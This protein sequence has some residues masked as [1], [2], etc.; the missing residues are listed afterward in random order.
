M[1]LHLNVSIRLKISLWALSKIMLFGLLLWVGI[2]LPP[3]AL[4]QEP[5]P[6]C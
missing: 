1:R 4:A 5:S 3:V 6:E 2:S